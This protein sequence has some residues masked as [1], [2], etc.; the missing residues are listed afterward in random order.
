MYIF[1]Q[2]L[3]HKYYAT[4][5]LFKQS[6]ASLNLEFSIFLTDCLIK[7]KEPSLLYK[8]SLARVGSIWIHA[9]GIRMKWNAN[10]LV[11][12]LNLTC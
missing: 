10:R 11:Q 9:L 1:T 3:S 12:D 5:S 2:L 6:K 7:A 8:I 4:Q